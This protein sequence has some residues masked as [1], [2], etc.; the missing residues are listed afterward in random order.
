MEKMKTSDSSWIASLK[1]ELNSLARKNKRSPRMALLG[2][3]NEIIGDDG[4]G[5]FIARILHER[6]TAN[7]DWLILDTGPA[8]MNFSTTLKKFSPD[9]ILLVDAAEMGLSAGAI[10]WL[11][12]SMLDGFGGSTHTFP[13]SLVAQFNFAELGC[14][15][16]LIG[17]QPFRLEIGE[18]LSKPVLES[19]NIIVNNIFKL[20]NIN[21]KIA[22]DES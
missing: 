14:T 19:A 10:V 22:V 12:W 20:S 8:P 4:A 3:G 2:I 13:L 7:P 5:V 21:L 9:F 16:G 11:D 17:I 1:N 6:M 18:G 15:I